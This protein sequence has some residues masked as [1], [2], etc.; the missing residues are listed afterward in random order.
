M[1]LIHLWMLLLT[2]NDQLINSSWKMSVFRVIVVRIWP[3]LDWI[4]RNTSY[5]FVFRTNAGKFGPEWLRMQTPFTQC[6]NINLHTNFCF[7]MPGT[8]YEVSFSNLISNVSFKVSNVVHCIQKFSHQC[9][10]QINFV[11]FSWFW[12][13]LGVGVSV[14]VEPLKKK[15]LW[16]KCVFS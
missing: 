10:I 2:T 8:P 16:Q 9:K 1:L 15:D 6:K 3:N 5:L 11:T 4:R 7:M 14:W 12:L 13:L